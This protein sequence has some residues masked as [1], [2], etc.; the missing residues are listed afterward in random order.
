MMKLRLE[1]IRNAALNLG[2]DT[3]ITMVLTD[4]NQ[5]VHIELLQAVGTDDG[6]EIA[7]YLL[8]DLNLETI[9]YS[10]LV[11]A[12]ERYDTNAY[13][14]FPFPFNRAITDPDVEN[15]IVDVN[16]EGARRIANNEIGAVRYFITV[17][18]NERV[19]VLGYSGIIETS[20]LDIDIGILA[21]VNTDVVSQQLLGQALTRVFP[22]VIGG[23]IVLMILLIPISNWMIVP[24]IVRLRQAVM[25][26]VRG[27]FDQPVPDTNRQDELGTLATSFIDMREYVR[28]LIDDMNRQLRE[29]TRDVQITQDISRAITAEHDV[30]RLME[31]VVQLI[32]DNFPSI[33]HAQI[34]IVD[35]ESD[36]AVLKAS[37]GQAGEALLS[38]GHK[39]AVGSVSVIGQVTEQGQVVIARDASESDVHRRNEFLRETLAELAIP[40]RLGQQII[41][42]LDVQSKQR[43]A[44][45]ADLVGA[46]Q[47]L[48]DQVTIAIE[49][50][51]LYAESE[52]LLS[53]LERDRSA[54]TLRN[55]QQYLYSQ[56]QNELLKLAGTLTGYSFETL[57]RAV[58][59]S[60]KAVVGEKTER[61][62]IPFVVPIN[63]RGQVLGVV[64]YELPH[65]DFS[66]DKVLLAEELVTRMAI[67][68]ENARLF[69][70]SQQAVERE[71]IV[72]EISAKLTGQTDINLI[73]QTA[74]QEIGQALKT[75]QVAI[76]LKPIDGNSNG[77]SSNGANQ[78]GSSNGTSKEQS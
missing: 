37:T 52:R 41:G 26:I 34:F 58:Y 67:G 47:T 56:R 76:R 22:L 29:R 19:E 64:E 78:N 9:I 74:V 75:P 65:T 14:L 27:D 33:Y 35:H 31:R 38:R 11:Q 7:G 60:G 5:R 69:Q 59:E 17:E 43:D 24:P 49:N 3:T 53:T 50:A 28:T 66:Y 61:D 57:S 73:L 42:A 54:A 46:L 36:F 10:N 25:G 72:N 51:R 63:L 62:T 23:T 20:L 21:E 4:H 6:T 77:S 13:L 16:S 48:S 1:N 32:V 30:Q 40:L 39:L 55:W 15:A 44:F 71:R 68:L 2:D 70:T 45:D 8:A 18:D 12:E